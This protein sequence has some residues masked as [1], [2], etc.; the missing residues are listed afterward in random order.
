MTTAQ[1]TTATS[2][3]SEAYSPAAARTAWRWWVLSATSISVLLASLNMSTLVIA[4]PHLIRDLHTSVLEA[5]WTLL[6]YILAQSAVVLSVGRLGDI[7][8]RRRLFITGIA[9]FTATALLSGFAPNADV[10]IGL[11]V[12]AGLSAALIVASSSAIVTDAFPRN[13]LGLA[14]GINGMV[15]AVGSAIGPVLGG[16]LVGLA[17]QWVFW[18]NV[19]LGVLTTLWAALIIREPART[20]TPEPIDWPGNA[21]FVIALSGLLIGLSMG[22]LQGWTQPLVIGGF[23][24][25]AVGLPVFLRIELGRRYPLLDLRLFRNKL[26]A[27]ANATQ[28]V[29]ATARIGMLFI[30]V[31]Y[32]QGPQQH[33]AVVA[34]VLTIP[35]A[36]VIILAS[37]VS[38]WLSDRIGSRIPSSLGMVMTAGGLITMAS[39]LEVDTSYWKLALCMTLTGLGAGLFQSPNAQA[40]MGSVE[41][42]QR[43]VASGVRVLGS[44]VG[45]MLSIAFVLA[46]VTS[47]LPHEVTLQI[48]SGI[49]TGIDAGALS[50]F[51]ASVRVALLT[52]GLLSLV[53]VPVS[54]RRGA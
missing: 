49:T 12:V 15:L 17:W 46:I 11:R 52:L 39:V 24:A 18:F 45:V 37:P 8:G 9:A 30:L 14:L 53:C 47:S 20:R 2:A 42:Y 1:T 6:A 50:S 25:F 28:L 34:G 38:G 48:F 23:V 41:P 27:I 7:W 19:P 22:G 44:F 16:V 36:A 33:D 51:I 3:P 40:I 13:E 43:G 35:L 21:I 26:F 31:F 54:W 10:L 29:N 4:L 5:T 32:F